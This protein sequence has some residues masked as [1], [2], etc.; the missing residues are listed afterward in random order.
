MQVVNSEFSRY[1]QMFILT[2]NLYFHKE[3]TYKPIGENSNYQNYWILRKENNISNIQSFKN[4]NP[5][6][7][8]YSL[9]WDEMKLNKQSSLL[10]NILRRILEVYF[11]HF[12]GLNIDQE[13]IKFDGSDKLI[14]ASLVKWAHDG[15]H[16]YQDDLYMQHR[17]AD[18]EKFLKVFEQI[19]INSGHKNHFKMM[20]KEIDNKTG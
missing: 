1:T 15:S 9:L 5:I 14:C 13:I 7:N 3:I 4:E 12:G 8:S 20:T 19:F 6:K 16:H 17:S 11:R 10:P 2:H 18:N